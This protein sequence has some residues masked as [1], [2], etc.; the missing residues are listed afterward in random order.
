MDGSGYGLVG[1][2]NDEL[3]TIM[4]DNSFELFVTVDKN[5]PYQQNLQRLSL[6]IFVLRAKD[7]TRVL[8]HRLK[9]M[10]K[11][12]PVVICFQTF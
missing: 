7:N 11:S 6:T 12:K 4:I 8:S 2:K 3:P 5:L 1:K 9:K 10:F